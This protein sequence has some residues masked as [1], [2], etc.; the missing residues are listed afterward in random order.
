MTSW[1]EKLT[2][3]F[4]HPESKKVSIPEGVW[5][6]CPNC[7]ETIYGKD[8]KKS[9]KVC[10]TCGF[11][12]LLCATERI[13][14]LTDADSFKELYANLTP[15]DPIKFVD[16]KPYPERV[17]MAKRKTGL[18][19]AVLTGD[20]KINGRLV[21]LAVLDFGFM[22]G[23]MGS[24]MGEKITRLIE[25]SADTN[26]PLIV[27][28]ASGGARMQEGI[29][30]L[31]QMAKTSIALNLLKDQHLAY[32]SL[33]TYPTMGGVSASFAMLGDVILAEPGSL[34]GFAGPRVIKQTI[35]QDLPKQF[36]RAEEQLEHGGIDR[37]VK[38][39]DLKDELSKI[40]DYLTAN[41]Q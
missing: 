18:T 15:E 30:S 9:L 27:V 33:L 3:N 8:L 40:L 2:P 25:H 29:L 14:Q 12:F 23:S 37:V 16:S 11:H 10:T 13:E 7:K 38:R 22:G 24:V 39:G 20:A 1:F 28:S 26:Q 21:S 19:E 34:I 41:I 36:Q 31:M 35:K 32:I 5:H 4:L 6:K 17:K